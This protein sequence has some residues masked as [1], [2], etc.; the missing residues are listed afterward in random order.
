MII[1]NKWSPTDLCH[2][3]LADDS[4]GQ[5]LL[6]AGGDKLEAECTHH[7]DDMMSLLRCT[8]LE[9]LYAD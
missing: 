3:L 7:T 8:L 4:A 9:A 5:Q 1:E 6:V 2:A